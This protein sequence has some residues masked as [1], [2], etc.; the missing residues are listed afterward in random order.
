MP[1]SLSLEPRRSHLLLISIIP[2]PRLSWRL[3]AKR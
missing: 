2:F 1:P 3:T